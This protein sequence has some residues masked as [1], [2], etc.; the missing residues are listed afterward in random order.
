MSAHA[1]AHVHLCDCACVSHTV[2]QMHVCVCVSR[3]AMSPPW[4]VLRVLAGFLAHPTAAACTFRVA[5]A[6]LLPPLLLDTVQCETT[7]APAC[8]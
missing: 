3:G 4:G 8:L 7:N 6:S 2:T 1:D 5:C